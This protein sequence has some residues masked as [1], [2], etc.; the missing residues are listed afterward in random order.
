MN[1][2][3]REQLLKRIQVL[4]QMVNAQGLDVCP[5][6]GGVMR[7][8]PKYPGQYQCQ[9]DKGHCGEWILKSLPPRNKR[10][11]WP[12]AFFKRTR[13][14]NG[15]VERYNSGGVFAKVVFIAGKPVDPDPFSV[16]DEE[17]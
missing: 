5:A 13:T 8:S 15:R 10:G 14:K 4:E 12:H 6:C 16:G 1:E 7:Q 17:E 9:N 11:E 3:D 2:Q